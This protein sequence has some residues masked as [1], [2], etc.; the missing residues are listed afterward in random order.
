MKTKMILKRMCF[1]LVALMFALTMFSCSEKKTPVDTG[2]ETTTSAEDETGVIEDYRTLL[3]D[4]TF[5]GSDVSIFCYDANEEEMHFIG[6]SDSADEYQQSIYSRNAMIEEK[7]DVILEFPKTYDTDGSNGKGAFVTACE[8]AKLSGKSDYD[9]ILPQR[10]YSLE[11]DDYLLNLSNYDV[12]NLDNPYYAQGINDKLNLNGNMYMIVGYANRGIVSDSMVLFSNYYTEVDLGIHDDIIDAINHK[13]WTIDKMTEYMRMA[14]QDLNGDGIDVNDK[15]GLAYKLHSGRAFLASAGLSLMNMNEN[16]TLENTIISDKN[17][18]IFD[19]IK[20]FLVTNSYSYYGGQL[21]LNESDESAGRV[22]INGNALFFADNIAFASSAVETYAK[23]GIY[24]MPTLNKGDNFITY[25]K[26]CSMFAIPVN[27]PDPEKSAT[28]IEAMNILSYLD[29][30]PV[31]Y[32]KLLKGRYSMDP[33]ISSMIDL[34]VDS[35][36]VSVSWVHTD[37]FSRV[38]DAPFDAVIGKKGYASHMSGY[39]LQFDTK[40]ETFNKIYGFGS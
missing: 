16:G 29:V 26:E 39:D 30:M 40:V 9:I 7:Y 22:Y 15:V 24:P 13:E 32:D 23:F 8:K 34:I 18:N 10:F 35:I 28:I 27:A 2:T 36:N 1:V 25:I 38:D 33:D 17:I 31:Y 4:V 11:K 3:P 37:Y 12:L 5:G 6:E 21:G 14:T 20:R 19:S